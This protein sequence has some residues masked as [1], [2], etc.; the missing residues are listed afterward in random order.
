MSSDHKE[1]E[2]GYTPMEFKKTLQGQFTTHTPYSYSEVSE[3][4]WNIIVDDEMMIVVIQVLEAPPRVISMLVLPVLNVTFTFMQASKEQQD[5]FL[6]TF[7]KY[8]HKGGG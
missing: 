1:F 3:N 6:K 8:F 7:F 4:H 2:M 5:D